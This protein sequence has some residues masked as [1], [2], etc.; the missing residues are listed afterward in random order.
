M[1]KEGCEWGVGRLHN[2]V[3]HGLYRTPIIVREN[4]SRTLRWAGHVVR[5]AEGNNS[6]KLLTGKSTGNRPLRRARRRW[7]E[8]TRV[9]LKEM[10]FIARNWTESTQVLIIGKTLCMRY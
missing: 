2:E 10:D 6:F 4:K 8:N 9:D 7:E 3:L 5:M 1:S